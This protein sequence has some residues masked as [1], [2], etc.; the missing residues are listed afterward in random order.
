MDTSSVVHFAVVSVN[1]AENILRVGQIYCHG[2][3]TNLQVTGDLE[4]K[5]PTDLQKITNSHG[6]GQDKI[7]VL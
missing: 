6:S 3:T 5:I 1:V 4:P 2:E 7:V